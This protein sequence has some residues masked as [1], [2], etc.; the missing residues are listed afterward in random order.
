MGNSLLDR[1]R[2]CTRLTP[3]ESRIADFLQRTYPEVVFETA[4]SIAKKVG[5]SKPTVVR[6]ISRLGYESFT[7]FQEYLQ[8]EVQARLDRPIERYPLRKKQVMEGAS[9]VLGKNFAYITKNLREA[10]A[11][12]KDSQF[13]KAA[14]ELAL[15][16]GSVYI[17]G[18]LS[19]FG[20]AHY[21]WYYLNYLR[22]HVYLLDNLGSTLPGRLFH[23]TKQDVLF[24]ITHRR[25]SR[26]TQ[27]VAEHFAQKGGRI[28]VLADGEVTPVSHLAKIL[29][30]AP[31]A[32]V[33]MFDSCC[34][35][36]AVIESL[37]TVITHLLEQS[38]EL[39]FEVADSLFERFSSFTPG[40]QS[41]RKK[42][43]PPR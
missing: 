34:A 28:L 30:V 26:N 21:L 13:Q 31:S 10:Q 12:I 37:L 39:R 33:S 40:P 25:Y 16:P 18:N 22:D 11:R 29:L 20:I 2:S 3:S 1:I 9:D 14:R 15:S 27:L 7:Q 32:S 35:F 6:Y 36:L 41:A 4:T 38:L 8:Q 19:S 5:V 24:V 23:V 42:M 43:L 17:V